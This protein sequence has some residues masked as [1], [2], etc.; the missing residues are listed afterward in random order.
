MSFGPLDNCKRGT[1][2]QFL[3]DQILDGSG[4]SVVSACFTIHAYQ[5]LRDALDRIDY[6]GFLLG[7]E[8]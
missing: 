3:R 8:K 5:A 4:L 1:V 6:P 2:A 7:K